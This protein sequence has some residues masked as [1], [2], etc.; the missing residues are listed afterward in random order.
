MEHEDEMNDLR[1]QFQALQKQQ[2]KRKLDRTKEKEPDKLNVIETQEDLDLSKQGIQAENVEHR[3]LQKDKQPLLDQLRELK[4]ENGR[5][6]KL[7]SEKDFEIKH[8]NKKREEERLVLAG[9][10]GLAG[11]IAA[12]K[13]VELSKKNREL[14]V[15]IEREKIKSKQNSNRVK[16]LEKELQAALVFSPP[17][18]K[19]ITKSQ[20]K[21]SEDCEQEHPVVK[22]LQEKLAAAQLKAT[23][24]RNQVQSAK[25]ELKVAQKVLTSEIGEEVNFQQLLNSP[26]SFRGRSQQIMALQ[27]RVRDL[28]QQLNRSTQQRQ[29]SILSLEEELFDKKVLQKTLPQE[30]NLS[31]IR[32]IEK[33]KREA[34]ER[35]SADYE[36]ILKDHEDVKKKLE[37]SKA[38]NK[39][40]STEIKSLKV[41]ISTLLEK[42]THDNEL[43]DALLKQQSQMQEV[44]RQ[45]GQQQIVQSQETP[46][47]QQLSS[48]PFQHNAVIH[49]LRQTVAER[50]A[51]IKELEDQI[52]QLS[53]N[54][55][56]DERQSKT[57]LCSTG[58]PPEEGDIDKRITFSGS[59]SKFGHKLVLPAVGSSIEFKEQET[60]QEE[61]RK[62][63]E[64][65]VESTQIDPK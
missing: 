31:Y 52:Q 12:T 25:Q 50:E 27:T 13:I 28:E 23:E 3:L 57:T 7:L 5:L 40:L 64:K 1:L 65:Q 36:A 46:S 60:N 32:T 15:E 47:R 38:R 59:V 22:S 11:D 9:T 51:R 2:E 14:N 56:S 55:E 19:I 20:H 42:E 48:E 54:Q 35:I 26:G 43:V 58:S 39:S 61:R 18:Q 49:R 8:L 29:P 4:D 10:S 6:F 63:L 34:Y 33:E 53:V 21:T 44:L 17:G 62:I 37:A 41:Q 30:R 16:E 24:Y 45:L